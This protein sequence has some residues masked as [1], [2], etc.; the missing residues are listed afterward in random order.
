MAYRKIY[1]NLYDEFYDP[2]EAYS[3]EPRAFCYEV[4]TQLINLAKK[5]A[6]DWY[7]NIN[8]TKGILLLLYTWNF[9]AKETK[10]ISFQDIGEL[11]RAT[12]SDLKSLEKYSIRTADDAVWDSV[13]RVFDQFRALLG[14]TGASK[15]LSLLNPELFVMWDTAIRKCLQRELIPGIMNGESGKH[16]VVFLKGIQGIIAKHRISDRLPPD[17]I[18]A[19]KIDEYHY[20]TIV[21]GKKK[22]GKRRDSRTERGEVVGLAGIHMPKNLRGRSIHANVIPTVCNLRNMLAKLKALNGDVSLLRPWEK[23]SYDAYRID[24]IKSRILE[25]PEESWRE[26]VRDHILGGNPSGFGASC[27][28][29]YLVAYVSETFGVGKEAFLKYI[30][31]SGISQKTNAAKAIWQVGKSDGV[32][33]GILND[34]GTIKDKTFMLSWITG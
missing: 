19:K 2:S 4:S 34:D 21:M 27:I 33:L 22:G 14:Q 18:I 31:K 28:D 7:E 23:R 24:E 9:A 17:T 1:S 32:Y 10:K 26:I 12:K 6:S 11:L 20:V 16:Y 8:T 13:G 25:S 15:A 3:N 5:A 29:I 30:K